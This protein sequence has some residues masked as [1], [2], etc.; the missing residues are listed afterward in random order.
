MKIRTFESWATRDKV[1]GKLQYE[2]FLSPIVLKEFAQY[3]NENTVQSDWNVRE[4]DNWQKWIPL[5]AYMDSAWRHFMDWWLWHRW[6]D[7]REWIIKALCWLM[8]NV[9]WYLYELIKDRDKRK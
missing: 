4:P 9:Q 8:F 1:D 5:N 3:M 2:W 7:N 6:Y